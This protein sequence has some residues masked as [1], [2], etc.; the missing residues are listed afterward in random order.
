MS[1]DAASLSLPG[2]TDGTVDLGDVS[3]HYVSSGDGPLIL[4]LHGFPEFWYAW[5]RLLAHFGKNFTAVAPD[6]RGFN[7]SDKPADVKAYRPKFLVQDIDR[8][9]N[10]FG[11]GEGQKFI[12]AGHD[13]GGAVA[14][15]Y[16]I[17]R[18]E[19]LSHLIC[20]NAPHP[21]RFETLLATDPAQK[22]ASQYMT[23]FGDPATEQ[24]LSANNFAA[25][26]TWILDPGVEKGFLTPAEADLYRRAW[27][28][29]G[30]L[31]GGLNYYR[32][33]GGSSSRPLDPALTRV[34]V[35]TLMVWGMEDRYLLPQ[36]TEGLE[37]LIDDL[38]L[39]RVDDADHWIIHQK[40]ELIIR[41]IEGFLGS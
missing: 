14:W 32:A 37:D 4:F 9:A 19:R 23:D 17:G 36:N 35:P 5:H 21:A 16:A 33:R 29:P 31:T 8:L 2:L 6:M 3:L 18:P 34:R 38:T 11:V 30:A 13:W 28:V 7:L 25:L 22:A 1:T 26:S 40:P 27:A 20:I 15:A 24:R 12:L 39:T 41:E 10:H